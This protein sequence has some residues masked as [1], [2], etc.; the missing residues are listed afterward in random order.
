MLAPPEWRGLGQALGSCDI[1][2]NSMDPFIAIRV[3]S[4]TDRA[5]NVGL[6]A[7]QIR[8]MSRD[9]CDVTTQQP[10]F[11][12]LAVSVITVVLPHF[13]ACPNAATKRAERRTVRSISSGNGRKK[14][15][16]V[17]DVVRHCMASRTRGHFCPESEPLQCDSDSIPRKETG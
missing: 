15:F 10:S 6:G 3:Y 12:R 8:S 13:G 5:N 16:A 4:H 14:H 17:Y 7:L 2:T 1:G 11:L 9:S